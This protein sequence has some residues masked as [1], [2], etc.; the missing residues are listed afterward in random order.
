M[1][2]RHILQSKKERDD[3]KR[4]RGRSHPPETPPR[5]RGGDEMPSRSPNDDRERANNPP[6]KRGGDDPTP[7]W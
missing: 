1:N 7:D 5:K 3:P 6:V 2:E 4:E